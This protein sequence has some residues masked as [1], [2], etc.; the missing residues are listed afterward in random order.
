MEKQALG[1]KRIQLTGMIYVTQMKRPLLQLL[2][3]FIVFDM[4]ALYFTYVIYTQSG[5]I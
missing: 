1:L 5:I 2:L 3:V 4:L